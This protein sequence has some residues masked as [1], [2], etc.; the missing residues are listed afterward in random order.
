VY[1]YRQTCEDDNLKSLQRGVCTLKGDGVESWWNRPAG[2]TSL[3][4]R[5]YELTS[6]ISMSHQTPLVAAD[7]TAMAPHLTLYIVS[8]SQQGII[9]LEI[10]RDFC[11]NR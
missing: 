8:V 4:L 5:R 11:V 2:S 7:D 1:K 9:D 3:I 10:T 6:L